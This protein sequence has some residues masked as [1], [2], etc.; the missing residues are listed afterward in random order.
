MTRRNLLAL[1]SSFGA[2]STLHAAAP[3]AEGGKR[4]AVEF[5]DAEWKQRLSPAQ[6]D[7]LRR[8]GTERAVHQPAEQ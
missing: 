7:V 2:A 6:Y 4:F 8:E 1:F 3:Q 5:S